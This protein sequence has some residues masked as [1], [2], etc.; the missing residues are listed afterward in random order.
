M[1]IQNVSILNK[2]SNW[3]PPHVQYT[4]KSQKHPPKKKLGH[5]QTDRQA[6]F[7]PFESVK[8]AICN[9]MQLAVN[10]IRTYYRNDHGRRVII[11]ITI[12]VVT[13]PSHRI[14]A[15]AIGWWKLQ[16]EEKPPNYV[17]KKKNIAILLSAFLSICFY[18]CWYDERSEGH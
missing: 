12:V 11:T 4:S 10:D 9:R 2:L 13:S 17:R 18:H 7:S 5:R 6:S 15:I 3:F 16:L 1:L 14:G 8:S